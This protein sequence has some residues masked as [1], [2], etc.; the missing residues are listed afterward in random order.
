V[1]TGVKYLPFGPFTSL[2][3]GNGIQET[4][5][6]DGD[7]RLTNLA[8]A[9][10]AKLLGLSYGYD[11]AG[12]VLSITDGIRAANNQ[13]FVYDGL[14]HLTSA[15]GG[16]GVLSF[17]YDVNGNRTVLRV[18]STATN[19][20]YAASS[21][22]LTSIAAGTSTQTIGYSAAGNIASIS[23]GTVSGLIY[24]QAGR[25]AQVMSGTQILA[26]YAYDAFGHRLMKSSGAGVSLF[27]FDGSGRLLE[28][29]G[30]NGQAITDYIYLDGRVVAT[31][32]PAT[33][34]LSFV[35]TDRLGTPQLVT[36]TKQAVLWSAIYQPFGQ[37]SPVGSIAQSLRFPGQYADAET[38]WNQNGFRD[39][40]P[41]IGRYLESDPLGVAAGFNTY[42]YALDSPISHSDMH[43]LSSDNGG[44]MADDI[45][46]AS[47]I[48]GLISGAEDKTKYLEHAFP[49]SGF[50][51][52]VGGLGP[53]A[54]GLGAAADLAKGCDPYRV[55]TKLGAGFAA[56]ALADAAVAFARPAVPA[57]VAFGITFA[58][59][60][61]IGEAA[62]A[63]YDLL[64]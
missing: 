10:T 7:Y 49:S 45:G 1:V 61:E 56:A 12:N 42:A 52:F 26:Q 6:Y 46:K 21:N 35:H 34:V 36:D 54:D 47:E 58:I 24:N 39:Y 28:E 41:S 62:G 23:S 25:L 53:F 20:A 8:D 44:G 27:Q 30:A 18:G 3:Y 19:Y 63:I 43:G 50:G 33:G 51:K 15:T 59:G 48:G 13:K 31:L 40:V 29:D 2:T 38:G 55:G 32:A 37:T 16:Y 9:G 14:N 57:I 5:G 4:R 64:R 60:W 17:T 11:A 22:R